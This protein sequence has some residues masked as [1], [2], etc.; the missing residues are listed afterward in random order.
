[1]N[2]MNRNY[3]NYNIKSFLQWMQLTCTR[4]KIFSEDEQEA[5]LKIFKRWVENS[6][7]FLF[8]LKCLIGTLGNLLQIC[9][10]NVLTF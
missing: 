3:K 8:E 1:M 2:K 5:E 10:S 9:R 6:V 4:V 7:T